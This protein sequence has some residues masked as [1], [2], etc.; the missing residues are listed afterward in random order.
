MAEAAL[1]KP[2]GRTPKS[3]D[4]SKLLSC[5]VTAYTTTFFM[6]F[7]PFVYPSAVL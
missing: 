4:K 2:L 6:C 5:M 3:D 7:L 1:A